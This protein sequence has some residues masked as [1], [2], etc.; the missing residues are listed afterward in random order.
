MAPE[1][2]KGEEYNL[3]ADIWSLGCVLF[4]CMALKPPFSGTNIMAVTR[5]VVEATPEALP[6]RYSD[7]VKI[8]CK[9]LL[10][11]RPEKRP[12]APQILQTPLLITVR[13]EL[14]RVANPNWRGGGGQL[15]AVGAASVTRAPAGPA[16]SLR[17]NGSDLEGKTVCKACAVM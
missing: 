9:E 1:L 2:Y 3:S 11:K 10:S 15:G 4:E 14:E 8:L 12:S 16:G 17:R 7:D 13:S 6:L 5:A